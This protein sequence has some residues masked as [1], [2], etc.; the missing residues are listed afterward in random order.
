MT[1]GDA[2]GSTRDRWA[3]LRRVEFLA[4]LDDASLTEL[5]DR[6]DVEHHAAGDRI[7]GELESGA[8]VYVLVAGR[9]EVI[10]EPRAGRAAC[11]TRWCRAARSARWRR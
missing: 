10:V 4:P 1:T 8:D 5:I 2:A 9:A 7:V 6:A 3:L 11:S